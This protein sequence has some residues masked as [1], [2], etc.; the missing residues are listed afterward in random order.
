M[1]KKIKQ[2]LKSLKDYI[3]IFILIFRKSN[4]DSKVFCIGYNK[5]GTTSLGRSLK[6]LGYK[7]S[8]FNKIVWKKYY[9]NNRID[10]VLKYTAKFD[11]L[12]DLPWLKEEMIPILD[13][14]FPN[15]KF[16]YLIREEEAWKKSLNNW[17]YKKFEKHPDLE[18]SLEEYKSHKDFVLDYFKKRSEEDFIILDIKDPEGFKK[19]GLFLGKTTSRDDFPHFNKGN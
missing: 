15:S 5:T 14:K 19:L 17:S 13:K 1:N 12:D 8:S 9:L 10:K 4:Y 3:K 18:K 2:N 11:S 7:N 6:M 16:I